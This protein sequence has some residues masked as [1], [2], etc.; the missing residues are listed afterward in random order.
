MINTPDIQN[1]INVD[2]GIH[3]G[4]VCNILSEA[5]AKTNY[6]NEKRTLRCILFLAEKDVSKLKDNILMATADPRDVML[7]AEYEN[8]GSSFNPKRLRDF[9]K[10][11]GKELLKK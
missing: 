7:C 6:L 9:N 1:R 11:F 4:E 2:F 8:S 3:A 5:I 10:P